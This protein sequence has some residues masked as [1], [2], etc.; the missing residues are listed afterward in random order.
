MYFTYREGHRTETISTVVSKRRDRQ[1][2]INIHKLLAT[3]SSC[4][5]VVAARTSSP[6]VSRTATPLEVLK[7][8]P[9]VTKLRH[10]IMLTFSSR[11][12]RR[13]ILLDILHSGDGASS[14]N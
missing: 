14:L 7:L 2:D 10:S 6:L 1:I 3:V 12:M 5:D 11:E 8:R 9:K 4:S 13:I